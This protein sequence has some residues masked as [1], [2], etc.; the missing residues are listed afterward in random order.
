MTLSRDTTVQFTAVYY[1]VFI[2]LVG[3]TG[4]VISNSVGS[5]RPW[6]NTAVTCL[7]ERDGWWAGK[8]L[9]CYYMHIYVR[10]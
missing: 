3:S 5:Q 8:C 9:T 2:C 1:P 7:L 10:M 6:G 4:A